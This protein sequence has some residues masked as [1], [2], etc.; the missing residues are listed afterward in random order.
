[1]KFSA[2]RSREIRMWTS[3]GLYA[4]YLVAMLVLWNRMYGDFHPIRDAK[5]KLHE[6]TNRRK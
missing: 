5:E 4:T 1:M 3:T 2:D 6:V